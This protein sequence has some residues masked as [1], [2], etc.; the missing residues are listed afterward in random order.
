MVPPLLLDV[1]PDHLVLDACASPGS[2]TT[3]II[4]I[5]HKD[6]VDPRK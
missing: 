2:K 5:M 3:Q 4:E 6:N 1:Q